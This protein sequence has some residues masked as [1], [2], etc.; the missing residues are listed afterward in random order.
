[1]TG[2]KGF[3][4]VFWEVIAT[5]Q[6]STSASWPSAS[7]GW[8]LDGASPR[9][10][11]TEGRGRP[12]AIVMPRSLMA[13]TPVTGR[14]AMKLVFG[15]RRRSRNRPGHPLK[16]ETME[17]D[18]NPDPCS[19]SSRSRP[20]ARRARPGART[21][22]GRLAIAALCGHLPGLI[23]APSS[24]Q[25]SEPPTNP[26]RF[27]L[28]PEADEAGGCLIRPIR[29]FSTRW[30]AEGRAGTHDRMGPVHYWPL[31]AAKA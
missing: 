24:T 15:L 20:T 2:G 9:W 10:R 5:D 23:M 30:A 3:S 17:D 14:G 4:T 31:Q 29:P 19:R 21:P 6:H 27:S 25:E 1:M 12:N 22:C 16:V 13:F 8:H 7:I 18:R 11:A 26:G 28:H